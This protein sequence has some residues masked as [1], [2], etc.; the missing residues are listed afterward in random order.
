M[1]NKMYIVGPDMERVTV[2]PDLHEKLNLLARR[3]YEEIGNT[4]PEGFD[5]SESSHPTERLMYTQALMA[6]EFHLNIGLD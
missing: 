5:F 1:P 6:Y 4:V 2:D 3:F